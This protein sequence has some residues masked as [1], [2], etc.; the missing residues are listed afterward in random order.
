M[1]IK[2]K[3]AI[4]LYKKYDGNHNMI[5]KELGCSREYIRQILTPLGY[6]ATRARLADPNG[7]KAAFFEKYGH[8]NKTEVR[9]QTWKS[10]GYMNAVEKVVGKK[11][12][13]G[14]TTKKWTESELLDIY[15]KAEYKYT[16][17]A[18]IMGIRPSSV[19]TILHRYGLQEK[20]PS[21]WG[22]GR[23]GLC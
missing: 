20:M 19:V 15:T 7:E 22:K 11:F 10:F 2:V 9:H 8:L 18:K 17:M 23:R 14:K 6:P 12:P 3:E 5:A 13:S 16:A 1:T 4:K 21:R